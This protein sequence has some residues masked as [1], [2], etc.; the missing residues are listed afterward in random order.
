MAFIK[1][2][3][4]P[5][6]NRDQTNYTNEGGWFACDKIRFRSGYPQKL[7]G[8]MKTTS[9]VFLGVCRQMFGWITSYDDNFVALGT[10]KKVYINV[11]SQY[12][13]ITPLRETT[14]AG[15]VTFAAVTTAPYSSVIT[16]TDTNANVD[17][18]DFVTFSGAVTLGGNITAAVL[19]QEYEVYES[20]TSS[21]YTII[22]K[23]PTTGLPV[24]SDASDSGNGGSAVVGAYQ[25]PIG[26]DTTTYGYGWGSGTWGSSPWGLGGSSPIVLMQRDWFFDNFDNDLVM[27]IRDGEIY[28]WVRGARNDI[29]TQLATRAVLLS[30]LAGAENVPVQAMQVFVSQNDKHLLAF[31]CTPYGSTSTADFDPLLIRWAAQDA[32]EFWTPGTVIVPSTGNL[33]SAGF[34]RVSRGSSIVRAT[35]TRQ[36]ILVWTNSHLYSLQYTGTTEV[37]NLQELADNISIMSPRAVASANNVTYWMGTDK[38]YGFAG[39]VETLPCTLR[40]HVFNNLNYNQKNQVIAGTNEGYHE[41]WWFYP[42]ANSE[43]VD[44]YVVYNYLER[45]WFYGSLDRTAWL[46]SPLR[47]YP[48]AVGYDNILMDHEKGVD[49][50][51]LPME[52]YIQSSDFDLADGDQFMLTRRIIPDVNLEGSTAATPE[53]DFLIKPRNF[54][55]ST[56][57]SD[58]FDTQAVVQSS[59]NVYTDQIWIRARARQMALKIQS[60]DLGVNWQLGSPRLDARAD[61]KR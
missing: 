11:G 1:L 2:Q 28:Y 57:Q 44:S 21:T 58:S 47:A 40:N 39:A 51:T 17:A 41:I 49:A 33:S 12:Y 23:S 59:V 30:S 43:Q 16:V 24:T 42:S 5:G 15:A 14:A 8:W 60:Q 55:G 6:V 36:T 20:L 25:I 26:Y 31:G 22:A 34:I 18:G 46:D 3:F 19:N 35:P 38:F 13:D 50:D 27:N 7:G 56:Y 10:S 61:G 54:P 45:L 32:P 52:S 9:Q 29:S 53:I 37:F 48:Q 4:R